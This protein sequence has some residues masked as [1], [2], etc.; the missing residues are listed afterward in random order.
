MNRGSIIFIGL[1]SSGK[2]SVG[3]RVSEA[4]KLTHRDTDREIEQHYFA[5]EGKALTVFEIFHELGD[6][7]FRAL[8]SKVLMGLPNDPSVI[9]CGGGTILLEENRMELKRRGFII[10]LKACL[11]TLE[12][13]MR[14]CRFPLYLDREGELERVAGARFPIYEALADHAIETDERT[15]EE[16]AAISLEVYAKQ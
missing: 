15:I 14:K 13:R 16:C 11:Q 2:S 5:R 9:S 1:F 8:E 7:A 6:P 10:Y 12:A 4:L 3:K